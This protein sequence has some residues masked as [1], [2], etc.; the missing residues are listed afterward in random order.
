VVLVLPRGELGRTRL[1]DLP[2]PTFETPE[3]RTVI[4][5]RQ[6]FELQAG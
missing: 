2:P 1:D 3:G 4:Y 6:W 5:Q